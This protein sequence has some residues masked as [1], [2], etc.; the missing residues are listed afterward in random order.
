M[1]KKYFAE[2]VSLNFRLHAELKEVLET[3]LEALPFMPLGTDLP[4]D[5]GI[6]RN[7]QEQVQLTNQVREMKHLYC[8]ISLLP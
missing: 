7:L 5:E 8:F 3:Q 1:L 2:L 6:V 4:A